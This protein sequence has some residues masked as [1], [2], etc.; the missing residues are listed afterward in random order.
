VPGR[1]VSLYASVGDNVRKGQTVAIVESRAIG[2][3][4]SSYRQAVARF[5]NANSNLNV[6]L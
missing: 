5:D 6:V 2:E 1:V 3:A 4:Q